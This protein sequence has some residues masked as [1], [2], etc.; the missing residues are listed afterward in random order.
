VDSR[1]S[2]RN[3]VKPKEEAQNKGTTALSV[4]KR[5]F[6]LWGIEEKF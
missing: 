1:D 5:D 6:F 3:T 4:L 2:F